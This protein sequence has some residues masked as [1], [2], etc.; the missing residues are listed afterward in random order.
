ML[1]THFVK[2]KKRSIYW[3]KKDAFAEPVENCMVQQG[4]VARFQACVH[5]AEAR[6][7]LLGVAQ[8]FQLAAFCEVL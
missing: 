3:P 2:K 7:H 8:R 4:E 5:K 1:H 6:D